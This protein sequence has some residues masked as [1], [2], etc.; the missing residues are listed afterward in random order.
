MDQSEK[1]VAYF[2]RGYNCAQ[3][4]A[5]AFAAEFGID[6]ATVLKTLSGFGAGMGGLRQTCGAVSA[7]AYVAGLCAGDYSP[8]DSDAKMALYALVKSMA[9]KFEAQ[10]GTT[11]CRDLLKRADCL[12]KPEPSRRT[13]EYYAARP[14]ARF[15][16]SA[17]SII[18]STLKKP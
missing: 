7:M 2:N 10:H 18:G 16:A 17:A 15:V 1:A 13:A 14:C 8:D 5:A 4:T 11:V 3:A 6:E 12:A 9:A